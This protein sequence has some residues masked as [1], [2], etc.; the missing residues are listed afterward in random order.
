[1]GLNQSRVSDKP[2]M[3]VKHLRGRSLQIDFDSGTRRL[4]R[5]GWFLADLR[6]RLPSAYRLSIT[7]LLDWSSQANPSELA[8]LRE[9]IDEIV[10][11]TY[12]GRRTI[13]NYNA[14]VASL[15][16]LRIP[17]KIGLVPGGEWQAPGGLAE[18]PWFR[19]YV[20]FL[21]NPAPG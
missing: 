1:M 6:A 13:S 2:V 20:V 16:H 21:I 3:V 12:Q 17:F 18:N 8:A 11:Q 9:T 19:G 7:G 5:Y 4:E 14:Y 15:A 10:L